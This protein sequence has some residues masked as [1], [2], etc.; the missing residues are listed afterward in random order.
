MALKDTKTKV[1]SQD[2]M[3]IPQHIRTA[4]LTAVVK[5][6]S[7]LQAIAFFQWRLRTRVNPTNEE[8]E[9]LQEV[10]ATRM[11]ALYRPL[12]SGCGHTLPPTFTTKKKEIAFYKTFAQTFGKQDRP[13]HITSIE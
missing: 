3:S 5:K 10:I 12:L 4:A 6:A 11:R 2:I 13:Y 7:E 8:T 1:L 9:L